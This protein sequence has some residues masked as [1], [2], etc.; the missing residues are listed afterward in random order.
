MW[1][2]VSDSVHS[3]KFPKTQPIGA[4]KTIQALFT[5][6]NVLYSAVCNVSPLGHTAYPRPLTG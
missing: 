3:G 2:E 5:F 6:S 4:V 1:K